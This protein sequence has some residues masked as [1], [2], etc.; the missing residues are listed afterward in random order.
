MIT[1]MTKENIDRVK[2]GQMKQAGIEV[3]APDDLRVGD[4]VT[5]I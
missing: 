3:P 4:Q 1:P 2:N 5:F